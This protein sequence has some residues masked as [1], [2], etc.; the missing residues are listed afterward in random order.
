MTKDD[1]GKPFI[2]DTLIIKGNTIP[3]KIGMLAQSKL[4]FF[5]DNPRIYSIVRADTDEPTQDEIEG[6][7]RNEDHVKILK[8]DIERNGGLIDP[9]IVRE[10]A[11]YVIEGNSRL[12]AY[13]ILAESNALRWAN[14]KCQLLPASFDN[15]LLSSLLGQYHLKGK[16]EWKPYEQAGFLHRRFHQQ[17]VPLA[18]L[19][20]EMNDGKTKLQQYIDTYQFMID[21]DDNKPDRWSYYYEYLRSTKIQKAG[22]DFANFDSIIVKKVKS[23]EI[24]SAQE[25]RDKL[26]VICQSPKVL[27]KFVGEK[28]EFE[29][30]VVEAEESGVTSD[31]YQKLHRF[32]MW[33]VGADAKSKLVA[34][35]GPGADKTKFEVEKIHKATKEIL[36]SIA[37][38]K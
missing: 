8:S 18:D 20:E 13:R 33:I 24:T 38:A 3:V 29:D 19:A 31:A 11:F 7:L 15:S 36:D 14:I 23:G 10:G 6:V 1:T 12:A 30:A 22:K 34:S 25:L 21:H 5:A 26:P 27:K 28:V 35:K 4:H 2:E 37:K 16:K 9:V 17:N 32:R